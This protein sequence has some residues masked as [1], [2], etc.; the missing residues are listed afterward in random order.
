M[1]L[2]CA[3]RINGIEEREANADLTLH[4]DVLGAPLP[5]TA[6]IT[7]VQYGCEAPPCG[8]LAE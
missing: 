6:I 5:S 7:V 8:L 1:K 2:A 3:M 4:S